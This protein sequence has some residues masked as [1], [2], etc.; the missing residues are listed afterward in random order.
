M[1][2]LSEIARELKFRQKLRNLSNQDLEII[3]KIVKTE[4]LT[5]NKTKK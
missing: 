5:R 2:H 3:Y 4:W 1:K